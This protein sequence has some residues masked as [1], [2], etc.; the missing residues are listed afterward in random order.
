M[1]RFVDFDW[2]IELYGDDW[3]EEVQNYKIL[4]ADIRRNIVNAPYITLREDEI[5]DICAEKAPRG[6]Y[7]YFRWE[8]Y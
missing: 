4:L 8:N 1:K 2:L 5:A 7:D 6:D 3:P